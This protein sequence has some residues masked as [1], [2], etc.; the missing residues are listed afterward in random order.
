M[1]RGM[2]YIF[3]TLM[4]RISQVV[5]EAYTNDQVTVFLDNV[6]MTFCIIPESFHLM[7]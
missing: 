7:L 1:D 4:F 6:V 2:L 5:L 3:L